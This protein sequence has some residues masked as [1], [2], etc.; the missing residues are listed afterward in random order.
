MPED[1]CP[2]GPVAGFS[3]GTEGHDSRMLK[4]YRFDHPEELDVLGIR[5]GP[6]AFNELH[7]EF[8]ELLRDTNF[9]L[10]RKTD[11]LRLG[12]VT[13]RRIVNFE[14]RGLRRRECRYVTDSGD[15]SCDAAAR[16]RGFI[17]MRVAGT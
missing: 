13:Q 2:Y 1:F 8:I 11:I 17:D 4:R 14:R 10:Y 9:V 12:A 16:L 5:A 3:C 15:V 7:T 6:P